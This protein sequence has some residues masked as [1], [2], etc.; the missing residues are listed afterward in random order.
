MNIKKLLTPLSI[1]V[2]A[3]AAIGTPA[4]AQVVSCDSPII[5]SGIEQ[6][7]DN[8]NFKFRANSTRLINIRNI[9]TLRPA[10]LQAI[11]TLGRD[12]N[13]GRIDGC[14]RR[15]PFINT[16]LSD[17]AGCATVEHHQTFGILAN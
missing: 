14:V 3:A 5:R 9:V 10:A 17:Q 15:N 1:A 8:A 2:C 11:E 4:S 13:Q 6:Q 7:C 16:E 12:I